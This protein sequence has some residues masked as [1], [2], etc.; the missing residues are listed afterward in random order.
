MDSTQKKILYIRFCYWL[1]A[2]IDGLVAIYMILYIIFGT[3]IYMKS[4]IPTQETQYIMTSGATLM[5]GWTFILIWGD[6]K[7]IQ[8]RGLLLLTVF[9][10]IVLF[11]IFDITLFLM[12][13][14]WIS[15]ETTLTASII[16]PILIIILMTG[17]F[18]AKKLAQ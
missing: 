13:N 6:Q 3:P 18:S 2:I 11:L 9:P 5:V 7:P 17:Y 4:P 8:R 12:G 15:L 16:R 1:G 14:K 10:V